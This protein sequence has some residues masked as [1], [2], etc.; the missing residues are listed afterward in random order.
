MRQISSSATFLYKKILPV[1]WFGALGAF[2]VVSL[3][4][5]D[6]ELR[7]PTVFVV[8]GVMGLITFFAVKN[9]LWNLVDE[10]HDCGDHLLIRNRG[11]EYQVALADITNVSSTIMNPPRIALSLARDLGEDSPGSVVTFSPPKPFS[12]NPF[13]RNPVAED[14]IR[15]V[16]QARSRQTG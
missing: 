13:A 15:R 4:S 1:I 16:N 9:L 2:M 14:L 11:R 12:L 8:L 6:A 10:V 5:R 7:N 3:T